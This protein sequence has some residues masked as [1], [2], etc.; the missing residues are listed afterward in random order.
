MLLFV[1]LSSSM[2]RLV[3]CGVFFL[4]VH[5][6][7]VVE[8]EKNMASGLYLNPSALYKKERDFPSFF[9]FLRR[10]FV[11]WGL[12]P[13]LVLTPHPFRYVAENRCWFVVCVLGCHRNR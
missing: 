8:R 9:F 3:F 4:V 5:L 12:I 7:T 13:F 11:S 6:P 1:C 10:C 2:L